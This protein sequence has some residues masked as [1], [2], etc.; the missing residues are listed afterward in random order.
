M[1]QSSSS[2]IVWITIIVIVLVLVGAVWYYFASSLPETGETGASETIAT[3]AV[4]LEN[5]LRAEQLEGL[6]S[7][8]DEI[9]RQLAQ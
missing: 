7:E 1:N 4:E 3:E 5:E 8:L 6:D 9:D 2:K